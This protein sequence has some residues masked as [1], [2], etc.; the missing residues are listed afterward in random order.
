MKVKHLL[1]PALLLV[2]TCALASSAWSVLA[3]APAIEHSSDSTQRMLSAVTTTTLYAVADGYICSGSP[4]TNFHVAPY[5][6]GAYLAVGFG[7]CLGGDTSGEM[8]SLIKFDLSSIPSGHLIR[9]A[10]LELYLNGAG[11]AGVSAPSPIALR[12]MRNDWSETGVTWDN[13]DDVDPDR[14]VVDVGPGVGFYCS[15]DAR[16]LV[17]QWHS[18]LYDNYGFMLRSRDTIDRWR[19]FISRHSGGYPPRLVISHSPRALTISASGS[20]VVLSW[21]PI[22]DAVSYYVYRNTDPYVNSPGGQPLTVTS[23][24]SYT[25]PGKLD[26]LPNYYYLVTAVLDP[27]GETDPFDEV[28]KFRFELQPGS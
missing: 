11:G 7:Q 9:S 5:P 17:G 24:L 3:G 16:I 6:Y 8:R 2:V 15:W 25:D 14:D 13:A 20:D 21:D 28:G 22:A 26:A 27:G 19:Y 23:D 18:G 12:R 1:G 4:Y 10:S